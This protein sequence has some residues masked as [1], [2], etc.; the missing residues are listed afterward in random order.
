[1]PLPED[2]SAL[3]DLAEAEELRTVQPDGSTVIVRRP[4]PFSAAGA[5]QMMGDAPLFFTDAD[6]VSWE[7]VYY[8]AGGPYKRRLPGV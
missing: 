7:V 2:L 8:F 4:L 6:G 1:M 5:R 3:P